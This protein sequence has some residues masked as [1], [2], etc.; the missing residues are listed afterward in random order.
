MIRP[1]RKVDLGLCQFCGEP[2]REFTYGWGCT[3][4]GC[5]SFI[6][7]NDKF[8]SD[9]LKHKINRSNAVR[10]LVGDTVTFYGVEIHHV[11]HDV[12]IGLGFDRSGQYK[13]RYTMKYLDYDVKKDPNLTWE[14]E[15]EY[16][17]TGFDVLNEG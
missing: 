14:V 17:V 12:E 15:E 2:I 5:G 6:F 3:G 16:E 8:F 9:V 13:Y 1:K 7:R 11:K 4:S 10:L